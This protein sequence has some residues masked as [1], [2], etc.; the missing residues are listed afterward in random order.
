MSNIMKIYSISENFPFL[1]N[2][3]HDFFVRK[4]MMNKE[5][6][7]I[8][9][10]NNIELI[11]NIIGYEIRSIVLSCESRKKPILSLTSC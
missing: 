10:K 9:Q 2:Y 6:N 7:L 8:S 5:C 1:D 4:P 11:F 3:T